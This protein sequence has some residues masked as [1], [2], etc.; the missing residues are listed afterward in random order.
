[1][2]LPIKVFQ[3]FFV[4]LDLPVALTRNDEVSMRSWST[5]ISTNRKP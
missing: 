2:Q 5:T 1:M 3:P 4:D